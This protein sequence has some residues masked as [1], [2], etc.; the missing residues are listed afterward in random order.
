MEECE[1]CKREKE[2]TEIKNYVVTYKSWE[3]YNCCCEDCARQC[4]VRDSISEDE[5]EDIE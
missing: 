4:A 5:I 2:I 1:Y 3:A